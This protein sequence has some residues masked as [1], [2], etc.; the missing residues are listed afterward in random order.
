MKEASVAL[1]KSF[2][3]STF[4][5]IN[6]E[7]MVEHLERFL[8]GQQ[9]SVSVGQPVKGTAAEAIAQNVSQKK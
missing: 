1:G 4:F 6:G 5:R 2:H 3:H 7:Q 9:V 8:A